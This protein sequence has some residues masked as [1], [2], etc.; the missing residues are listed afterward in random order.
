[1]NT[2]PRTDHE[3]GDVLH[4][5]LDLLRRGWCVIPIRPGEK[6]PDCKWKRYQT[7][8]PTE[9]DLHSWFRAGDKNLAVMCGAVSGGLACR[10]FDK[11]DAYRA[12]A[13]ANPK[14]A[15]T[16]PTVKTGR[17]MH[18]YFR[19]PEAWLGTIKHFDNG[20]GE[21]RAGG[22]C[23]LPPSRHPDGPTYEWVVPLPD[24]PLPIIDHPHEVGLIPSNLCN[25]EGRDNGDTRDNGDYRSKQKTT[26]SIGR[27]GL[28]S[29]DQIRS[30]PDVAALLNE[31]LPSAVGNRNR[32]V[33]ELARAMKANP[34]WADAGLTVL[35]PIVRT[36]HDEGRR[37]GV[38]QTEAFEETWIDFS[39]AWPKILYAK[40]QGPMTEM[41][42]AARRS[43]P[44]TCAERYSQQA[45]RLLVALCR[46][47][48]M[49]AG[50]REFYLSCHTAGRLLDVRHTTAWRWLFLLQQDGIL[51]LVKPGQRGGGKAARYRYRGD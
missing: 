16:L 18:V 25:R 14:L 28:F 29:S 42:E 15:K 8:L 38:I 49:H 46:Q 40:G 43:A 20:E 9:D 26:D 11:M 35:E 5:A 32:Q 21:Y 19:V 27:S 4:V 34:R 3:Q 41:L 36:W 12:W 13:D 24:G 17:G 2:T 33:F 31:T 6:K 48:Q 22:Y 7:E 23:L 10:D 45:V 39:L 51:E 50:D 47:L 30:E 37:Q 1:V 44:P